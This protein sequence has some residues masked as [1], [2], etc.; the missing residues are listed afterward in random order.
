MYR[1]NEEQTAVIEEVRRVADESIAPHAA[2]VDA[3]GRF[4]REAVDALAQAGLLGLTIPV[5]YGGMG[6]GIRVA[7][8]ALDEI[9]QRCASTAM[10]YLMHVC[11]CSCYVA[12]PQA[13]EDTLRQVARGAHL[14]TLAWS[15]KGSRSH[16]WA[17]VNQEAQNNGRIVLNAKK[18]WVTSAGEAEG[19]VVSTRTAGG[20]EP[21]D[22]TLYLLLKEDEGF[23]VS[24]RWN[25]LG[26]RGNASAPMTLEDCQIPSER[27]LC[28]PS[29]GFRTMLEVVL[30]WF[31]LGNAAV[32]V[33]IA[34]A[35]TSSTQSH[36]TSARLEHLDSRLCDLP[37]LRARLAKMR[38]ETDRAR[39]H[40]TSVI[41]AVENPDQN[42]VL[43]VLES[44]VA[45]A[46][47]AREVAEIGMQACGGA[48]FSRHLS[49]E[50]NFRDVHAASVM[51]PT[52]DVLYDFIGK[53][54]CGMDLF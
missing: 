52:S 18:S 50:R 25:G 24:D 43:L 10:I 17:P 12:H 6:H 29:D 49:M 26:M 41:E 39:A 28:E 16:F 47:T 51:A 35:A 54:L 34:E 8:A 7:C 15:E 40:L 22:T 2:D 14:T 46:E 19:Y 37:T 20:E 42:T 36:L 21:T 1:L 23:T 38:V 48:A 11:G 33:G 4:P 45:A 31:N 13:V 30:P 27:A 3:Q 53:A 5:E 9:A 32:S 44:K